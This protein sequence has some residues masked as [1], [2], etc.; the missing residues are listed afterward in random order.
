MAVFVVFWGL[1]F[2]FASR[3]FT[4]SKLE[5]LENHSLGVLTLQELHHGLG[6]VGK[7][8]SG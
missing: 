7:G 6:V 4:E 1:L 2:F 3:S 8:K 5:K